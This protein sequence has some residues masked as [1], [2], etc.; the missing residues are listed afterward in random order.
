VL[1]YVLQIQAFRTGRYPAEPQLPT[2]L[3][4]PAHLSEVTNS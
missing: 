2:G 3:S 1:T 4:V